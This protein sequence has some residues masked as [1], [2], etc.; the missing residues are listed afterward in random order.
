[1]TL[2]QLRIGARQA[3]NAPLG[4]TH[5]ILGLLQLIFCVQVSNSLFGTGRR[6]NTKNLVFETLPLV[7]G[8]DLPSCSV[9]YNS[10]ASTD[11]PK[12]TIKQPSSC[13]LFL[14]SPEMPCKTFAHLFK[15]RPCKAV[16]CSMLSQAH[17]CSEIW[18]L[19]KCFRDKAASSWTKFSSVRQDHIKGGQVYHTI[20]TRAMLHCH[21]T[22]LVT[23]DISRPI[24]DPHNPNAMS[25]CS[26]G[27]PLSKM[28]SV[29]PRLSSTKSLK[30]L[31]WLS[32]TPIWYT[33]HLKWRRQLLSH[34]S[35]SSHCS[36]KIENENLFHF[37]TPPL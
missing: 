15:L 2:G 4:V 3:K 23:H 9:H 1:M 28:I 24:S 11:V 16:P 13:Q 18:K 29:L 31:R 10:V 26:L 20:S 27:I 35:T 32:Q 30:T 36:K 8:L 6:S 22:S 14:I 5:S 17:R 25:P 19:Q 33:L 21:M 12:V 37:T 34:I 7:F